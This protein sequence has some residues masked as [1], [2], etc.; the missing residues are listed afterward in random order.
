MATA[1]ASGGHFVCEVLDDG[2]AIDLAAAERDVQAAREALALAAAAAAAQ[3]QRA[4]PKL[5]L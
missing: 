5:R 4:H 3:L 2:S 1:L